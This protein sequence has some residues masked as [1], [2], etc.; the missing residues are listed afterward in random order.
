MFLKAA[1]HLDLYDPDAV[2]DGT[3]SIVHAITARR[4]ETL[5]DVAWKLLCALIE[6]YALVLPLAA[7]IVQ[8][9]ELRDTLDDLIEELHHAAA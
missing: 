6:M 1:L 8:L 4:G 5:R 2:H 7:R 3:Y 9:E